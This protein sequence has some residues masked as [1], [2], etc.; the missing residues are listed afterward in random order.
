[1]AEIPTVSPIRRRCVDRIR[2]LAW[3]VLCI[4]TGCAGQSD[5]H[6]VYQYLDESTGV[7]VTTLSAPLAFFKDEPML[8]ANA[9]DYVYIGPA[10][11]NRTGKRETVLWV[12]FCSTIDRGRLPGS[13][14]PDRV[15]LLLDGK[16]M[17]LPEADRHNRVN[18]WSYV[19]PVSGGSTLVFRVTRR[20]LH[21]LADASDVR[22]L[23]EKDGN[24]RSYARWRGDQPRLQP[25]SRYLDD[26]TQYMLTSADE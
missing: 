15:F 24:T 13:Y 14:R 17:E 22:V 1:M 3:L 23:A 2:G 7:T 4:V 10:E 6:E 8:A 9:R 5:R 16:P 12:N 25:F 11:L 21:R 19:A 18:E 20:Q 26:E